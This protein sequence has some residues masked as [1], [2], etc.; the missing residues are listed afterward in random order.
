MRKA[1]KKLIVAATHAQ[2]RHYAQLMNWKRD[3]WA[4]VKSVDD[5]VGLHGIV[6]YDVRAARYVPSGSE[7]TRLELV[8][9]YIPIIQEA[10]R[11]AK[12][13]VYNLP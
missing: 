13:N 4:Y 7:A 3:E 11:I 6:L 5:L 1:D 8:R 12:L 10:G 2:A 9:A